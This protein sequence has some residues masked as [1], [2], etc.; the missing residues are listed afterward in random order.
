[1]QAE[2]DACIV[3]VTTIKE[4]KRLK[5]Y[6][7]WENF[8]CFEWIPVSAGDLVM[9]PA[10]MM[11]AVAEAFWHLRWEVSGALRIGLDYGRGRTLD[12]DKGLQ[13]LEPLLGLI[14]NTLHL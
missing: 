14:S 7:T 6:N 1:L 2:E 5:G 11:H 13:V 9:I 4:K 12:I 10:G 3:A 8:S